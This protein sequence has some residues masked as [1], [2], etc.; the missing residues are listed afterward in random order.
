MTK[1]LIIGI[2]GA[3]R[4]VIKPKLDQLPNF[5]KLIEEGKLKSIFN[6]KRN[7]CAKNYSNE[8]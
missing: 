2:D 7:N 8:E 1:L 6:I 3:T 5:K 4:R